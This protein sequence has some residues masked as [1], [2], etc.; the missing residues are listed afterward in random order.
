MATLEE[1][2]AA[3][4][5]PPPVV[6][7]TT[8]E[9]APQ[10]SQGDVD[11]ASS[12]PLFGSQDASSLQ[13]DDGAEDRD[14]TDESPLEGE[15]DD[16]EALAQ[17]GQAADSEEDLYLDISDDDMFEVKIDGQVEYRS[18]S[19][20]K[21]ALS[22]EVSVGKRLHEVSVLRAD[23]DAEQQR[24]TQQ[25]EQQRTEL[26]AFATQL[27]TFLFKPLVA[28]PNEALR[29]SDSNAYLSELD[30]YRADQTRI[31]TAKQQLAENIQRGKDAKATQLQ[32]R[33]AYN[34][35]QL[36]AKIPSLSDAK[37]APAIMKDIVQ[38]GRD[39]GFTDL[40]IGELFDHRSYKM[41]HDLVEFHKARKSIDVKVVTAEIEQTKTPRRLRS[42][43]ARRMSVAKQSAKARK[44]VVA[45]A[46]SSGKVDDI[47]AMIT[48]PG[49]RN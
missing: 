39:Y 35:T 44:A 3:I 27:D 12:D 28:Q 29:H 8:S 7:E 2:A 46:R 49:R 48:K 21:K 30:A 42:G 43:V 11:E 37:L 32:Q 23:M 33:Q 22:G 6:E 1:V 38:L 19:D 25:I 18:V 20:A 9:S 16:D 41:A 4:T 26:N 47:A 14:E 36:V 5:V 17:E 24:N 13:D 34:E 31:S 40:E 45:Q 15:T 10:S